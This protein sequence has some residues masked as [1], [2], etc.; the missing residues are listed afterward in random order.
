MRVR[1]RACFMHRAIDVRARSGQGNDT[2]FTGT[3]TLVS[4]WS[5]GVS[6]F[7]FTVPRCSFKLIHFILILCVR[8]DECVQCSTH[9]SENN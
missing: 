1:V 8:G 5:V 6:P 9:S 4:S 7:G 2:D 3:G